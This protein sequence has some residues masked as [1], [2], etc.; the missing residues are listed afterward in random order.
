MIKTIVR[1]EIYIAIC[2]DEQR[3]R[4]DIINLC[5]E[6]SKEFSYKFLIKEYD[7]GK[8]LLMDNDLEYDI[9]FLDVEMEGLSGIE[10]KNALQNSRHDGQILFITSHNERMPEAFGNNVF[11][12]V[13]KPIDK[14]YFFQQLNM[15]FDFMLGESK[16]IILNNF[17]KDKILNLKNVVYIEA[18]GHYSKM[19]IADSEECE[20]SDK[21]IGFWNEY[22][23]SNGFEMSKRNILINLAYV[24]RIGQNEVVMTTGECIELSRRGKKHFEDAFEKYIWKM[25]RY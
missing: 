18:D 23:C 9:L 7:N 17:S 22:L 12:F 25:G 24:S 8:D 1:D 16:T 6:Y 20:F 14:V 5:N 13:T 2:D 4:T 10:V 21:S 19:H 15:V 11:G 3:W